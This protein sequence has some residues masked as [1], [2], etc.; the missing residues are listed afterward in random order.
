M[1]QASRQYATAKS[2]TRA[3]RTMGLG[4]R[5]ATTHKDGGSQRHGA[6]AP[7]AYV[8]TTGS[9]MLDQFVPWYFGVAFTFLFKYCIDMLIL[10]ICSLVEFVF[11]NR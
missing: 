10:Y 7:E 1:D 4:R 9:A 6:L 8:V 3:A 5:V 11:E 2:G